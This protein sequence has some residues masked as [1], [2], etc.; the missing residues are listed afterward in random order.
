MLDVV[1]D[2][3]ER[4]LVYAPAA[5]ELEAFIASD[6]LTLLFFRGGER[7]H[8]EAHDVAVALREMLLDYQGRLRCAVFD[9]E[10][11]DKL[12]E[13]FRVVA[14]P[15]LVF[16]VSGQQ[17]EVLPGVRD[18]SDYQSAFQRYLGAPLREA[19]A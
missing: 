19:M 8:R 18:W 14:P 3:L 7:R 9:S 12:R 16:V 4:R 1:S 15:A 11:E 5:L 13:R 17:Q 2:M 10:M 6:G